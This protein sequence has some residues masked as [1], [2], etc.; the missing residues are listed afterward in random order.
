MLLRVWDLSEYTTGF[1]V[2]QDAKDGEQI[3]VEMWGSKGDADPVKYGETVITV[4]SEIPDEPEVTAVS[5]Y[6]NKILQGQE[7]DITVT[8]EGTNLEGHT[9]TANI[10]GK[11]AE[12]TDGKAVIH[13]DAE[14]VFEYGIF[15]TQVEV[16][17]TW[18]KFDTDPNG[19]VRAYS[20]P[21]D[22][23]T[24]YAERDESGNVVITFSKETAEY[25]ATDEWDQY[26]LPEISVREVLAGS[27][28]IDSS[29][30]SVEGNVVTISGIEPCQTIKLRGVTY[31]E[32]YAG[33][34]TE[35]I[36]VQ[37]GSH[38]TEIRNAKAATCTEEGYT[39]DEICKI[40]G[41]VIR[42]GEVIPMLEHE[43]ED[44]VVE[45]TADS[46]GYTIHTCKNC[47]YSYIDSYV[48]PIGTGKPG[49]NGDGN[50]GKDDSGT[51]KDSPAVTAGPK[52]GDSGNI[53]LWGICSVILMAALPGVFI[54]FRR[55]GK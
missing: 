39:G 51:D 21:E 6:P 18:I 30:I 23:E 42:K 53:V 31:G 12:V 9:V 32:I 36:L 50:T 17:G 25:A 34:E 2:P 24:T 27:E 19:L 13:L 11:T 8:V 33:A 43:Y 40:C 52:T 35:E 4:A 41:E 28:V 3:V 16:E 49:Q 45:P 37:G 26:A 44:E 5:V 47:G 15:K 54:V 10:L 48:D 14:D 7:A 46:Q 29:N 22:L 1:T 55:R 20:V 38:D